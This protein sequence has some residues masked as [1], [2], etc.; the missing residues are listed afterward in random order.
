MKQDT[1]GHD[2]LVRAT[3][4]DVATAPGGG[5]Y[6]SVPP[7]E[8]EE[9]EEGEAVAVEALSVPM[10]IEA[11]LDDDVLG[12]LEELV[13]EGELGGVVSL[14]VL[15]YSR[16]SSR[17]GL[18][19][20]VLYISTPA[21]E[22]ILSDDGDV[23]VSGAS[24][25][26]VAMLER[27]GIEL[28]DDPAA[29][30]SRH[31]M[32]DGSRALLSKKRK[33]NKN[34]GKSKKVAKKKKCRKK[35]LGDG[36][37][38]AGA[39]YNNNRKKC[40][41]DAGD[42][43]LSTNPLLEDDSLC[44]D[45]AAARA[46]SPPLPPSSPPAP[47]PSPP[48]PSPPPLLPSSPPP[49]PPPPL[50]AGADGDMNGPMGANTC[51][52]GFWPACEVGS[53]A[54]R[55]DWPG[56]ALSDDNGDLS[57]GAARV[58]KSDD[59]ATFDEWA[60][61]NSAYDPT[62]CINGGMSACCL[63]SHAEDERLTDCPVPYNDEVLTVTVG[64]RLTLRLPPSPCN[65]D[66]TTP[67]SGYNLITGE[68]V[69]AHQVSICGSGHDRYGCVHVDGLS[70]GP[71]SWLSVAYYGWE[72]P[73]GRDAYKQGAC[74][75]ARALHGSDSPGF[76]AGFGANLDE[77]FGVTSGEACCVNLVMFSLQVVAP[78]FGPVPAP[79]V[80]ADVMQPTSGWSAKT[81]LLKGTL[82]LCEVTV[83][84]CMAMSDQL[85]KVLAAQA[86]RTVNYQDVW[87][88]CRASRH[89]LGESDADG[90]QV[91]GCFIGESEVAFEIYM[92]NTL[93]WVAVDNFNTLTSAN[94]GEPNPTGVVTSPPSNYVLAHSLREEV[95][96]DSLA[97]EIDTAKVWLGEW[98]MYTA[99]S[100]SSVTNS[101]DFMAS[102]QGSRA[103]VTDSLDGR[104]TSLAGVS[105]AGLDAPARAALRTHNVL[106]ARAGVQALSW[107][108]EMAAV[109]TDYAHV[110][111]RD[112]SFV[113]SYDEH[114]WGENIYAHIPGGGE[115]AADAATHSA[116]MV[117]SW[118]NEVNYYRYGRIGRSC[119]LI[120]GYTAPEGAD[121]YARKVNMTGDVF[122]G[123][124][125]SLIAESARMVGHL[126]QLLHARASSV[127][128]GVVHCADSRAV[129]DAVESPADRTVGVCRYNVMQTTSELPFSPRAAAALV[130]DLE[131]LS[132]DDD[133][134]L[135]A[136][137]CDAPLTDAD[138][139]AHRAIDEAVVLT[140][141]SGDIA[142]AAPPPTA[143]CAAGLP[144]VYRPL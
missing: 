41:Y 27:A 100:C 90:L 69:V 97:V 44:K 91:G 96:A 142:G 86:Y 58:L 115:D 10:R 94:G 130:R 108:A 135:C 8:G 57:D 125:S 55:G 50:S 101:C 37:C 133:E 121:S 95:A 111:C 74:T 80:R 31:L 30:G 52:G 3:S 14:K 75:M 48:P 43:C 1:R 5:R 103:P 61:A 78:S 127:G 19:E 131:T 77:R 35:W 9:G 76:T 24:S 22:V 119:T 16:A 17:D 73:G 39:P 36:V 32:S 45:P 23:G 60:A 123:A 88:D 66:D 68:T 7:G 38:D 118:F 93:Q 104:L 113:H 136:V 42:C 2:V 6:W 4:N 20:R 89:D 12:A 85:R 46:P 53:H 79:V 25:D 26:L 34:K 132:A 138:R 116:R 102:G 82:Q 122:Q 72:Q 112:N 18:S 124:E 143:A 65:P 70:P 40:G 99:T 106:R 21:G 28:E 29:F 120:K 84:A 139:A 59:F 47:P 126:T 98:E 33:K 92:K 114:P 87:L 64:E 117:K 137:P 11:D 105:Y 51:A 110:L 49:P 141:S 134:A 144:D 63:N 54:L 67:I 56:Q 71:A 109:A 81:R 140:E 128:C 83:E 129:F 15:G 62:P 13:L 107:S